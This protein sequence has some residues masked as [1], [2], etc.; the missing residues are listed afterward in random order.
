MASAYTPGQISDFLNYINIPSKFHLENNPPR[1]FAFLKALH[2]HMISTV[3]Y[4]NLSLHYNYDHTI[5]IDPPHLFQKVVDDDR[6]RGGYCMEVSI[7]FNHILRGLGFQ[8]YTAGVRIRLREGGVPAGPF[9]GWRH[10]VNIVTLEDGSRYMLDVGFGGDGAT[11]PL[12]LTSGHSVHNLGTQEIRLIHDHIPNQTY[13]TETN[14]LWIYQYRNGSDLPWNSFYAFPE[15]EFFE[16]DFH[17]INWYTGASPESFQVSTPLIVKFLRRKKDGGD[18]EEVE[19]EEEIYGKRMLVYG[20]VKENLGGK[21]KV[22]QECKSEEERVKALE[23]HFGIKL[24]EDEI[25]GI[26]GHSTELKGPKEA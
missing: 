9:V 16:T 15:L 5:R 17:I 25:S 26:I 8:A 11:K 19:E 14:K 18:E 12:P 21:T 10:I 1:D 13:R 20:T 7:F 4:E 3:P 2:I 23:D 6:G 22:I 24:S